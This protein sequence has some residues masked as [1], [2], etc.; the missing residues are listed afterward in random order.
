[1]TLAGRAGLNPSFS[2]ARPITRTHAREVADKGL[3]SPASPA[4][5]AHGDV[6]A[7]EDEE[8][9]QEFIRS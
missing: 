9:Y 2:R 6:L 5:P 4:S 3:A 1:M 7:A 8:A